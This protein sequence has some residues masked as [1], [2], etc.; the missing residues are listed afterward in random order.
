MCLLKLFS[1][2][3]RKGCIDWE[4]ELLYAQLSYTYSLSHISCQNGS[5]NLFQLIV[6]MGR[7]VHMYLH[8]HCYM[9][10]YVKHDCNNELIKNREIQVYR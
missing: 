1:T 6:I 8:W 5:I 10:L 7:L 4:N 2:L 9:L 3:S